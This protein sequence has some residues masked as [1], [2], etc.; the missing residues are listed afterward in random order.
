MEHTLIPIRSGSNGREYDRAQLTTNSN[1]QETPHERVIILVWRND[2]Q[3]MLKE[4]FSSYDALRN[5][6]EQ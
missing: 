2:L 6:V 1:N 5:A 4:E 3:N